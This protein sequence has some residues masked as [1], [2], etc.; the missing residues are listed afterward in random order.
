MSK[1]TPKRH[2]SIGQYVIMQEIGHG[3]TS[4]VNLAKNTENNETVCVKILDKEELNCDENMKFFKKEIAIISALNHPNIVKYFELLEDI[5]YYYVFM[6]YCPGDS[7]HKIIDRPGRLSETYIANIFKQLIET[8][9]YLHETGF[10]HRDLKPDNIIVGPKSKIKLVD[11][12]LSTDD[13][14]K[15]RT[16]YCGS[17]AFAAPECILREPYLAPLADIWSAGVIL[18]MM[19]VKEVPWNT[20][21]LVQMMKKITAGSYTIPSTVPKDIQD[22]IR[23][24]LKINPS[25]RPTSSQILK[26]EWLMRDWSKPRPPSYYDDNHEQASYSAPS[27]ARHIPTHK[28]SSPRVTRPT[29]IHRVKSDPVFC[30]TPTPQIPSGSPSRAS[31]IRR[32]QTARGMNRRSRS[33]DRF[34]LGQTCD[35]YSSSILVNQN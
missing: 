26:T 1:I 18:Y 8:L 30:V 35:D 31:A 29:L 7:L 19:A 6:E 23:K 32:I 27:S 21:N 22:M 34:D 25:E 3:A 14:A 12:G 33:V 15:L 16:T 24:I 10:A 4:R 2:F 5:K 28:K 20:T 17:L 13:N 9:Q 11:F